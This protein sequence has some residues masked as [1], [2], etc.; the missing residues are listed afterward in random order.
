GSAPGSPLGAS[1]C[2]STGPP[3]GGS[4]GAAARRPSCAAR[5][6]SSRVRSRLRSFSASKGRGRGVCAGG[7]WGGIEHPRSV[8]GEHRAGEGPGP[9]VPPDGRNGRPRER[10]RSGP[11]I[12]DLVTTA[13]ELHILEEDGVVRGAQRMS[14][15]IRPVG[16][17]VEILEGQVG[18]G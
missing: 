13:P 9:A 11:R 10:R 3:P 5:S 14:G 17:L 15:T 12:R 8:K 16:V 4:R 1:S 7:R 18:E 6:R 2:T